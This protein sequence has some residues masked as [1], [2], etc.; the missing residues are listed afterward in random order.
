MP[1]QIKKSEQ[2]RPAM[3]GVGAGA[4]GGIIS[5]LAKGLKELVQPSQTE[6][7]KKHKEIQKVFGT[8]KKGK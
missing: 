6:S 8:K 2:K 4:G 7:L 3:S 1:N 5:L